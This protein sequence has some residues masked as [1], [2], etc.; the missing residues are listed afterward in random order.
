MNAL[1]QGQSEDYNR[2]IIETELKKHCLSM[3]TQELEATPSENIIAA[4][5]PMASSQGDFTYQ[6]FQID[7]GA[8]GTSCEFEPVTKKIEYPAIDI[9]TAEKKGRYIQFLEQ[10]FEWQNIA[11][12]FYHLF[13]GRPGELDCD[14]G[15]RRSDR[16]KCH[17][18]FD[19][20]LGPC[21]LGGDAGGVQ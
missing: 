11:Y 3:M 6:R 21:T 4:L 20:R 12:L 17:G 13:L 5:Q 1:L 19:R 8:R 7:E 9:D 2:A 18:I 16:P 14:D 10:A 15:T